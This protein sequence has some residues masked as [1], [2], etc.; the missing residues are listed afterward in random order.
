MMGQVVQMWTLISLLV[1]LSKELAQQAQWCFAQV[2]K[3]VILIVVVLR[4]S[5]SL[6]VRLR[7]QLTE[8]LSTNVFV[9]YSNEDYNRGFT[10]EGNVFRFDQSQTL[11]IGAKASYALNPRVSL[12]GGL[13]YIYTDYDDLDN[14]RIAQEPLL[15]K[16]VSST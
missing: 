8:Q 5:P 10:S 1:V 13:N 2:F 3:S 16:K 9:R 12:F 11:R 4:Q 7:S 15:V 6:K 14:P